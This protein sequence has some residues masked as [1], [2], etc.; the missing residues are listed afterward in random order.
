MSQYIAISKRFTLE[1]QAQ[2][3]KRLADSPFELKTP[4]TLQE[5]DYPNV[6]AVLDQPALVHTILA[7]PQHRL[8]W[9][10]VISTGIDSLP[11]TQLAK[12]NVWVTNGSGLQKQAVVEHTLG[13][14]LSFTR[15]LANS[16]VHHDEPRWHG[17][18]QKIV[19]LNEI[20]ILILGTG[21]IGQHLAK[22]LQAFGPVIAGVN[23]S[24]HAAEGFD[25]TL[26]FDHY[27]ES[28]A[29]YHVVVNLLPGT[30]ATENIFNASFFAK[31]ATDAAFINMGRGSA[32]VESD[33]LTA[34]N[35]GE[36]AAAFLDVF[37]TEPLPLNSPLRNIPQLYW[38]PHIGGLSTDLTARFFQLTATNLQNFL[39][40]KTPTLN[41]VDFR[42][43]Y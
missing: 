36:I 15:G 37:T 1:Q 20:K 33:L 40:G 14:I 39:Q 22:T 3:T 11:L 17:S 12:E 38:T 35:T 25:V 5:K 8:R 28:L 19:N 9:V 29:D 26:P 24:G 10:Q 16:F 32:V 21:I 2:L 13:A 42:R 6:V 23:T 34:L 43:G 18:T 31:M 7:L 27:Q 41:L 30:T 4:A